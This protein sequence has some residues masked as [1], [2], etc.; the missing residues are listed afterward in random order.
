MAI[1]GESGSGKTT[2]ACLLMGFWPPEQGS[3]RLNGKDCRQLPDV[4]I[5]SFFAPCLQGE[6]VFSGSVRENFLRIHPD[7]PET[8]IRK[9][10]SEAQLEESI[11]NLPQ[12]LDTPLGE[13]GSMLSGGERQ[14]LLIAFALASPAPILLLDEPT[15]GLDKKT[16]HDLMDGI[17]SHLNGRALLIITHDMVLA[18]RM[19]RIYRMDAS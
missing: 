5:R 12:G 8:S 6:Y 4:G 3:I 1:I 18:E 9:A 19:D 14:R 13:N 2:L 10:L 17:L 7:L 15:A 11:L 16:A